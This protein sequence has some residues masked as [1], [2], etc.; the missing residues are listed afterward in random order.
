MELFELILILLACVMAS[1]VADQFIPHLSLPLLQIAVGLVIAL[2][3]PVLTHVHIEA[4]L[5]LM[6]FIAPLL[7]RDSRE[8]SRVMLWSNRWSILSMAIALVIV[9]VLAAG[10]VLHQ[11]IPA[12]PLAAAFACAAALGP[13]DA[14]AV[15]AMGSTVNLSER[16]SILLSGEALINDASGVVAFQ[17]AIAAAV[18]G[19]FH[20][21]QALGTF[22]ILFFGGILVGILCGLFLNAG[23]RMLRRRGFMSVTTHVIFDVF[24]P[25]VIFLFAEEL[26]VSGILAVVA[27]GLVMQEPNVNIKSPE[28]A[29]QEMVTNSFWEVII[30][31]INGIL[32]VMLGMQLPMVL[33]AD[34]MEGLSPAHV[35]VAVLAV[36]FV[37]IAVRFL[38]VSGL[39][40]IHR[41]PENGE[42]GAA[43]FAATELQSLVT[44]IAGPKGAV[45]LSIIMT[46]PLTMTDGTAFAS[47]NL[48]IFITSGAILCTLLLA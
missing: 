42:R 39:E 27:T 13:T 19:A 28:L 47:R 9:S 25:F 31:L 11:I 29:R 1:A 3:L 6:L 4:E 14:A 34:N 24:T 7:Y 41:N 8:V 30:F 5:F 21:G 33:D 26:H 37:I 36:T 46:I 45:T 2:I 10:F 43:H 18:T 23:T 16:Q 48:I 35:I 20:A 17:F 38:W 40:L 44:T 32:F 12:I 22:A 15:A